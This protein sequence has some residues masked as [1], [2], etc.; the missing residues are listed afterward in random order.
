MAFDQRQM[1]GGS[2]GFGPQEVAAWPLI[3]RYDY[4]FVPNRKYLSSLA[5]VHGKKGK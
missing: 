1:L 2:T 5:Y 4:I 3:I